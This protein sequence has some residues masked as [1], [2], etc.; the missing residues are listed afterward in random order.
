[1]QFR[2]DPNFVR[3]QKPKKVSSEPEFEIGGTETLIKL[4]ADLSLLRV[5]QLA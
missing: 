3:K 4:Q 1:M 2:R 5:R